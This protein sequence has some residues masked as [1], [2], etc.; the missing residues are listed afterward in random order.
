MG[1]DVPPGTK[2]YKL[3]DSAISVAIIL[4]FKCVISFGIFVLFSTVV[5]R[6]KA[7]YN[8][9]LYAAARR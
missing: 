2:V 1:F 7:I 5:I 9:L 6:N 8:Q 3:I 4:T